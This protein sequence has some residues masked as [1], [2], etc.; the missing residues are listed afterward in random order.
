MIHKESGDFM[1]FKAQTSRYLS[2]LI[3]DKQRLLLLFLQPIV[4]AL[5][6]KFISNDDLYKYASHTHSIMFVV[7]CAG[8]WIGLFNSI[9]EI[10]KERSILKHEYNVGVRFLSYLVSRF[11]VQFLLSIVQALLFLAVFAPLVGMPSSST[12]F[13]NH[14]IE[15]FITIELTIFSSASIGLVFSSIAK[16][17]DR[18]MTIAPFI[19]IF[20]LLFSGALFT[21]E[22]SAKAIANFT[23][24]KWSENA[25]GSI[26]DLNSLTLE[27]QKEIPNAPHELQPQFEH[28]F[29]NLSHCW[30][31]MLAFIVISFIICLPALYRISKDSR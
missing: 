5:L 29:A 31:A 3:N 10:C 28:T 26:S 8:I 11:F 6:I 4:I 27:I 22:G 14:F 7:S 2:L 12:L 13:Q 19:L 23:I 20:Q 24:S 9:Q 17:S 21:L 16:N 30:L 1:Q 25:L 18:A 15:M